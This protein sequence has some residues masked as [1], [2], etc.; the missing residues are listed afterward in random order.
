[1]QRNPSFV[2][3]AKNCTI[4]K[5]I[6]LSRLLQEGQIGDRVAKTFKSALY[7]YASV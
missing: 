7:I 3:A 6:A 1:M 5:K 2:I 4:K